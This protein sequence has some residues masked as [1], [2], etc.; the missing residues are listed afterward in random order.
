VDADKLK[1]R[2]NEH[3]PS[4]RKKICLTDPK[5]APGSETARKIPGGANRK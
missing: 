2:E 3:V 5:G 4:S 1:K